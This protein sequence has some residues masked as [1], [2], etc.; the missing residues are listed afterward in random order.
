VSPKH[1]TVSFA[2]IN[3]L[4]QLVTYRRFGEAFV[5]LVARARHENPCAMIKCTTSILSKQASEYIKGRKENA[6]ARIHSERNN[7]V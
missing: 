4:W 2:K 1:G 6:Q 7:Q 5:F 3:Y